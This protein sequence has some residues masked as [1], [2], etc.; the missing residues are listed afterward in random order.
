[1]G[2]LNVQAVSEAGFDISP[3]NSLALA[4][5]FGR[6]GGVPNQKEESN[7]N[8]FR[9]YS[10]DLTS[11]KATNLG[12]TDRNL[13]GVAI[14][15]NPVAYGVDA[16]NNLLIFNPYNTSTILTRTITGLQPNERVLGIDM[17]PA[18]SQLYALGSSNRLYTV[19]LATGAF[20]AVSAT[21]FSPMLEGESFGFDFNP[22]V[23][24]IRVV[25]NTGQ[26]L[27]LN[28]VN[29]TLTMEDGQLMPISTSVDASAYTNN[30]AGATTTA[31]YNIDFLADALTLQNPPNMGTQEPRGSLG[32][33]IT[34]GNGFDIGGVSGMA[35]ALLQ[36]GGQTGVYSINLGTG[37]ATKISSL[38]RMPVSFALGLGF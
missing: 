16:S 21:P 4:V 12:K 36:S 20:A 15:T 14:P 24:R 25:S 9:F 8:K 37:R 22:T 3:D 32:V 38:S 18:T 10:I 30:F 13:I 5:L 31:L 26:N 23:D 1:V 6:G 7:G 29:G 19:N 2:R 35:L 28:P 33:A 11:G 17:R 34:A 27:R